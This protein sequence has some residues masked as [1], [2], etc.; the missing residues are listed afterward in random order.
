MAIYLTNIKKNVKNKTEHDFFY[1][2]NA[3]KQLTF[4]VVDEISAKFLFLFRE[5]S[6]N[7]AAV[8]QRNNT[9]W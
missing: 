9:F 4:R 6:W 7:S 3:W 8:F 2:K 1:K 5:I